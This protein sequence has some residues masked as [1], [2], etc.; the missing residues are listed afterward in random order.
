[1]ILV[2]TET[3]GGRK[4][5]KVFG[6]VKGSSIRAKWFGKD[7][8]SSLRFLVGGE[9]VEYTEMMEETR[10]FATQ[11]MINEAKR[12]GADAILNVRIST[13]QIMTGAAEVIIYGTAVRMK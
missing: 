13:S 9:L 1:M 2:T 6:L 10:Q 4:P 5:K 8:I 11:R 12:L 3:I 7:M